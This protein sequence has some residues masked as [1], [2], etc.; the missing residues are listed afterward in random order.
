[1]T[2][3]YGFDGWAGCVVRRRSRQT[4][5]IVGVYRADQADSEPRIRSAHEMLALADGSCDDGGDMVQRSIFC[6]TGR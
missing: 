4:G 1:M 5:R 6:K 2:R 3:P